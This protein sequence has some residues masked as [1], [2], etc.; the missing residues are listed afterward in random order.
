VLRRAGILPPKP[1]ES[2]LTEDLLHYFGQ[3]S[4]EDQERALTIVRALVEQ[5]TG[6][7][8]GT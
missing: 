5:G 2:E 4:P 6:R 3:L 7:G 8:R 1:E